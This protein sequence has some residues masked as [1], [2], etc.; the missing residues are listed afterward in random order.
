MSD[1]I[2][3]TYSRFLLLIFISGITLF[4]SLRGSCCQAPSVLCGMIKTKEKNTDIVNV[5]RV[6]R[7]S[8]KLIQPFF[9]PAKG[10]EWVSLNLLNMD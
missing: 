7:L 2:F 6:E 4:F 9:F 8:K 3:N 10:R 1:V 5:S